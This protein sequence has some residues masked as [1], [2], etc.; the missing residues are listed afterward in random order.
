MDRFASFAHRLTMRH[1]RVVH[2]LGQ[3]L[4]VSRAAQRLHTSQPA[5]ST[6]LREL[7]ELLEARLFD[8]TTRSMAMTDVG[9]TLWHHADRI[10]MEVDRTVEDLQLAAAGRGG[11]LQIGMVPQMPADL[12][13]GAVARLHAA[14][15]NYR[16][17]VHEDHAAALARQLV[18]GHLDG[19]I[20]HLAIGLQPLQLEVEELYQDSTCLV[21]AAGHPLAR[22]RRLEWDELRRQRWL[23]PPLSAPVRTRLERE[24]VLRGAP[25]LTGAVEVA[26]QAIIVPLLQRTGAIAVMNRRVAQQ[27][28]AAGTLAVLAHAFD[29]GVARFSLLRQPAASVRPALDR[30]WQALREEAREAGRLV[31]GSGP[32][33]SWPAARP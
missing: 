6:A 19:V 18:L 21:A 26:S 2:V 8:R 17:R 25:D 29:L 30:L 31:A 20:G 5:V 23:L 3:E 27:H 14:G 12:L 15:E 4:N 24:L 32:V 9:R 10:L 33:A 1:L 16:I 11:E 7:E 28:R 13:A 22:R